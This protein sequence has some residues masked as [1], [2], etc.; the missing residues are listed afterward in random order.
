MCVSCIKTVS[1]TSEKAFFFLFSSSNQMHP[2]VVLNVVEQFE[3][4]INRTVIQTHLEC[5][6]RRMQ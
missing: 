5:L 4:N 3:E 1:I 6:L 2:S